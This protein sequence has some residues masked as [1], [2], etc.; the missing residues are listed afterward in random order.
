MVGHVSATEHVYGY[1]YTCSGVD[2]GG[3]C[4][5][6]LACIYDWLWFPVWWSEL[7]VQSD[8]SGGTELSLWAYELYFD[9]EI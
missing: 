8:H 1:T 4:K 5:C 9:V 7:I 6:R 2:N 3:S